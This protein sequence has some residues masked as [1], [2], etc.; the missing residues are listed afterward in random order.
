MDEKGFLLGILGRSKRIFNKPLHEEG[1]KR[2][3]I[4][5]SS[6]EWI[7]LLACICTDGSYLAPTLIY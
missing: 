3:T 2:S 1:K 6:R 4:Q 7:T 5:D